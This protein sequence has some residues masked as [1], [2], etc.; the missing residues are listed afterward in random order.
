MEVSGEVGVIEA[1]RAGLGLAKHLYGKRRFAPWLLFPVYVAV[2]IAA[3]RL[4]E[5]AVPG[6][7]IVGI[8]L[9]SGVGF[10]AWIAWWRKET[11]Q[12]WRRRGVLDQVR[13]AYRIEPDAL[14]IDWSQVHTRIAWS[15]VSQ[16]APAR[17]GWIIIGPG[18]AYVLPARLFADAT[19]QQA[20]LTTCLARMTPEAAARSAQPVTA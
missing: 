2:M 19:A 3:A 15:A 6:G 13:A 7:G 11:L 10:W 12:A 1:Q 8:L 18:V 20:F 9:I 14:V 5:R 4:S 16:I 17:E